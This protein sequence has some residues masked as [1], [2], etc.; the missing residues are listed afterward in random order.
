MMAADN[1]QD[2]QA[3]VAA[4]DLRRNNHVAITRCEQRAAK[5]KRPLPGTIRF[6]A[7]QR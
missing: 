7:D 1:P 4:A 5:F 6:T 3:I 2:W